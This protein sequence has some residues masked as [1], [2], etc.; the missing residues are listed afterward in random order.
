MAARLLFVSK[1][2]GPPY[3]DGTKCLV[4]DIALHLKSVTPVVMTSRGARPF[5]AGSDH[6]VTWPVYASPGKYQPGLGQ[7][8]RAVWSLLSGADADIWHFVFAPNPKSSMM[9]AWLKRARGVP[10]LQ[11]I[12]SPPRH[13]EHPDKLVF[14]DI[15]V[16]Q[17]SW[18]R[19]RLEQAFRDA[20]LTAPRIEVIAPPVPALLPK[21]A[22]E[23]A[24]ARALLEI[25]EGA[26]MFVYPG[27]LETSSGARTIAALV[28]PLAE[29]VPGAVV[30]FAYRMKT[31]EAPAIAAKLQAELDP[32]S[33]RFSGDVPDVLALISSATAVVFPVDD[34]WG[35]VDLPIV[36]LESME[37]GVPV[38]A[39]DSGPL[40][41]LEG[42]VKIPDLD[43]QRLTEACEQLYATETHRREVIAAQ[44]ACVGRR[45]RAPLVSKAY[46]RLYSELLTA[47]RAYSLE[48]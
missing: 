16:A 13:F 10:A 9:G 6:V 24:R 30:V 8:L 47:S 5:E 36:L 34:L 27:D 32:A 45:H 31:A 3:Q 14:G 15:V 4:R 40:K 12:A 18:T 11:T 2:I 25:P 26:P 41:D 44:K 20:K 48:R 43:G 19:D 7:N 46:E 21:S 28:K 37:L 1:P 39:L 42:V 33:V 22:D 29:R 17:S 38:I 35:K 23:A